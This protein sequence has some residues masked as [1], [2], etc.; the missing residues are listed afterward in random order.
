VRRF[1]SL[2]PLDSHKLDFGRVPV[3]K[4]DYITARVELQ[5]LIQE[6]PTQTS[7]MDEQ[8]KFLEAYRTLSVVRVYGATEGWML[9]MLLGRGV[10]KGG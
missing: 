8:L 2:L 6:L 5:I 4:L 1:R 9:K 10:V 7:E 3:D